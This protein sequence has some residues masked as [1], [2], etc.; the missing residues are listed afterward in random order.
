LA[1]FSVAEA[2]FSG[3]RLLARRPLSALVWGLIYV[4]FL[5][6]VVTPFAGD[7]F[8]LFSAI[9]KMNGAPNPDALLPLLAPVAGFYFLF[10][11][12]ALV[13]VSVIS[14]AVYR[15]ELRPEESGFAY[16][17]LGSEE[18]W[19]LLVNFVQ[20]LV[21]IGAQIAMAIP[22]GVVIALISMGNLA[23]VA[24]ISRVGQ[25]VV[26]VVAIWLYLRFSLA[27]PMTFADRRFRLFDAWVL[28][29]GLG[30]RLLGVGAIVVALALAVY[31]VVLIVGLAAGMSL[32]NT[33]PHPANPA[34][35]LSAP[36]QDWASE[37]API[38]VLGGVLTTLAGTLLIPI[39]IAPW[40]HI[41]RHLQGSGVAA[42]FS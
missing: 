31:M 32:W 13:V 18:L 30:W 34:A 26:D 28:T 4:V 22:V 42:T 9:S 29:R 15:A 20:A 27:G 14:C 8:A 41:Y 23:S 38:L 1:K 19:V 39:F 37:L 35:L 36:P 7:L 17:R 10:I 12:G 21:M 6:V 25:A 2:A 5:V 24:V 16:L 11:V 3:V 40:A 33:M